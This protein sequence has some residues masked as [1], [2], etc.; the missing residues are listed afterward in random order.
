MPSLPVY[1]GVIFDTFDTSFWPNSDRSVTQPELRVRLSEHC[2]SHA[3]V[4]WVDLARYGCR[5][6]GYCQRGEGQ[7]SLNH[8]SGTL[9]E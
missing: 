5:D 7:G 4:A 1:L 8:S 6:F 3:W 9:V 2:L